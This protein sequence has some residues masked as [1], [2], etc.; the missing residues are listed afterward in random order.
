VYNTSRLPRERRRGGRSLITLTARSFH[1]SDRELVAFA[2]LGEVMLLNSWIFPPF[3]LV[4][5]V[6]Y[7]V[8]P[9]GGQNIMLLVASY[10]LLRVLGLALPGPSPGL[11]QFA[12]GFW[13]ERSAVSPLERAPSGGLPAVWG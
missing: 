13:L 12:I 5:L 10:F 1:P 7:H 6:L 2:R 8:L 9:H 3:L 4:V 11:D